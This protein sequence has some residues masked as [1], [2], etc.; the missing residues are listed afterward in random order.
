[1]QTC[2]FASEFIVG[3]ACFAG[4]L[5]YIPGQL[6]EENEVAD[7]VAEG[8]CGGWWAVDEAAVRGND[9]EEMRQFA[10]C[11]QHIT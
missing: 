10:L 4:V 6:G 8:H 11:Q 9:L 7:C 1:M 2:R 5:D 3:S